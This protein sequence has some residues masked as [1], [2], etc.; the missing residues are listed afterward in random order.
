MAVAAG[1][2]VIVPGLQRQ[3]MDARLEALRL[4]RM[5]ASAV[6]RRERKVVVGMLGGDPG[7]TTDAVV[8]S[9]RRQFESAHVHKQGNRL[10]GGI[11]LEQGVVTV[12]IEAITVFDAG[13]RRDRRQRQ[14]RKQQG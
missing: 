6:H 14:R 12:T 10:A 4:L 7:M 1:R 9:V 8:G 13:E 3:A 2:R 5:A 11:G